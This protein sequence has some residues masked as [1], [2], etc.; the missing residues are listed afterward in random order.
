MKLMDLEFANDILSAT[1]EEVDR[2]APKRIRAEIRE[3]KAAE[4]RK[5]RR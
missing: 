1:G 5:R 4:F 3:E 2:S